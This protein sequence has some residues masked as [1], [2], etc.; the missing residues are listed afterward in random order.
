MLIIKQH[1]FVAFLGLLVIRQNMKVSFENENQ[2]KSEKKFI[3]PHTTLKNWVE[4][5][6]L[7]KAEDN[8]KCLLRNIIVV[9]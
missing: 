9:P 7:C 6:W 3:A 2:K 8:V 4:L 1:A 5:Q